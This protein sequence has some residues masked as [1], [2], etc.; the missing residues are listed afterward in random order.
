M[1][2]K[3]PFCTGTD[4]AVMRAIRAYPGKRVNEMARLIEMSD[5]TFSHSLVDLQ[6]AGHIR[7]TKTASYR[8]AYTGGVLLDCAA[9]IERARKRIEN[10]GKAAS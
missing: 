5:A 6:R 7:K 2:T 3:N 4:L 8:V 1:R 9:R 10:A